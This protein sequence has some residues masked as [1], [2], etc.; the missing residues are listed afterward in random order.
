MSGRRVQITSR[1]SHRVWFIRQ[2]WSQSRE[3][4]ARCNERIQ[5]MTLEEAQ[6]AA[7]VD[8]QTIHSLIEAGELHASEVD[9]GRLL[10]WLNSLMSFRAVSK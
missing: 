3:F 2:A 5:M 4:C 9:E 10:V 7:G 6:A 1:D 8:L